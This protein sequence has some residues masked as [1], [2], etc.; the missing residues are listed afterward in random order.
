MIMA[1]TKQEV[2]EPA[3]KIL[4]T[5]VTFGPDVVFVPLPQEMWQPI[6]HGCACPE[7]KKGALAVWDTLV[8]PRNE[9]EANPRRVGERFYT[10]M[11]HYPEIAQKG[12]VY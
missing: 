7:C 5:A 2:P 12:R 1:D 8:V 3:V 4:S 10:S 9:K 6:G 11:C